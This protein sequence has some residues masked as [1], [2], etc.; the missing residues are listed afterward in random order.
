MA[1]A[2]RIHTRYPGVYKV[3]P[4][5]EWMTRGARGMADTLDEAR[6][7]KAKAEERGPVPAAVRG[8]FGEYARDWLAAYQGRTSRGFSESTRERYRQS[9]ELYAIPYFDEVRK[10]KIANIRRQHTKAFISWLAT[11]P[12]QPDEPGAGHRPLAPAT[13]ER[14]LAAVKAMFADA[15]EDDLLPTNPARVR[16]NLAPAT[17]DPEDE[18]SGE[19]RRFTD[20][21]LA[22]VLAAVREDHRLMF[23]LL[24][25]TGVRWGELAELRGRDLV[26]TAAGPHLRVQRAYS[27]ARPA[28]DK[29]RG[30]VKLPKTSYARR[31]LPLSPDLARRLWRLQRAPGELLFVN[32]ADGRLDYSNTRRHVLIPALKAASATD[33]GDVTWAGFHTFRHTVASRLFAEDRNVKKVSRWLG[34]HKASFT[35]DTYVHLLDDDLGGPLLPVAQTV[36]GKRGANSEAKAG[37]DGAPHDVAEGAHL[38][39]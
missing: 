6:K 11:A 18:G 31:D 24:D 8:S 28:P 39:A 20:D 7:A 4:R 22:A 16:I 5:Y 34:H 37:E 19:A 30:I 38:Q 25:A 14:T 3:G 23:D 33:A 13:V 2:K 26:T 17:V 9:L 29:P 36:G 35:L 15:V 10:L 1:K 32:G 27:N 21:Q 12:K